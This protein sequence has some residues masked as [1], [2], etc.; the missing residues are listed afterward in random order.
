[1]KVKLKKRIEKLSA[2]L[3]S[4]IIMNQTPYLVVETGTPTPIVDVTVQ[5]LI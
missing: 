5:D 3:Y 2:L 4:Q 1:M